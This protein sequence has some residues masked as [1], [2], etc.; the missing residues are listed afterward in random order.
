MT[1]F[2]SP[3]PKASVFTLETE[4]FQNAPLS[5]PFSKTSVFISVFKRFDVDDRRKRIKKYALMW[6]GP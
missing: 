6:S 4:R 5:K 2:S 3:F 1:L